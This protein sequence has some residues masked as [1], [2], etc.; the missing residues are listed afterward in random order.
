[1]SKDEGCFNRQY[2]VTKNGKY[3]ITYR[4][5]DVNVTELQYRSVKRP[6]NALSLNLSQLNFR[7]DPI[8]SNGVDIVKQIDALINKAKIS[9]TNNGKPVEETEQSIALNALQGF[10]R[11]WDSLMSKII[12][13]IV[14]IIALALILVSIILCCYCKKC[15]CKCKKW[16]CFKNKKVNTRTPPAI[17]VRQEDQQALVLFQPNTNRQIIPV[18]GLDFYRRQ[19]DSINFEDKV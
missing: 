10:T 7:H 4:H 16:N 5:G 11:W 6:F 15:T 9:M 17:P 8:I 18:N 2:Y 1:V 13:I 12:T 19:L 14:I 3:K